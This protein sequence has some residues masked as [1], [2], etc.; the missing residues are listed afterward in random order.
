MKT[1]IPSAMATVIVMAS[2]PAYAQSN[3]QSANKMI[4]QVIVSTPR[5]KAVAKTALPVTVLSGETLF[6]NIGNT[7]G[8]TLSTIPGLSSASFGPSVGQPVIRG[9]QGPRVSVL[10]N[11]MRS[12]DAST[13]SADH[14]VSVEPILADSI[15]VLRG[16]STL[17]YG[18]GAIGG[19]V[20]VIDGRIPTQVPKELGGAAEV[21]H[22]TVN[23]ETTA[24]FKLTGG[25]GNMAFY[26]DAM[27]R[28][29][30]DTE[31]PGLA[32]HEHEEDHDEGHD[33][34][35]EEET[36]DGFISNTQSETSSFTLGGSYVFDKG[37]IGLAVNQLDNEYG[38]P[39]GAHA[40]EEDEMAEE[41]E[42]E[43]VSLDIEQTR[44]DLKGQLEQVSDQI[45]SVR[46]FYTYTDYEHI[47]FEGDEVGTTWTRDSWENRVEVLHSELNGWRGAIGFQLA[48]YELEAVGEESYLPKTQTSNWGLFIVE[49]FTRG[50]WTYELGARIDDSEVEVD[51]ANESES[52][53][54]ISWSTS[55]LWQ[56]NEAWNI[57]LSFSSSE[58]APMAEEL[59]SNFGNMADDFVEHV[60]T[61]AIEVGD[62]DLDNEQANNLDLSFNYSHGVVNASVTVFYN[63]FSDY[64]YL[65]NTGEEQDETPI[66]EYRQEDATFHGV[67]FEVDVGLGSVAGGN[68]SLG[69]FGDWIDGELDDAGDVSRLPPQKLGS[70]LSFDM[71]K[72]SSYISVVDASDQDKPGANEEETEGYTR[73]DAGI[74]YSFIVQSDNE[75]LTFVKLKNISD[76]EIRN[77]S[78]FLR[79]VAP[80]AGRSLEAGVRFIF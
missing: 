57:G 18:G 19:V 26:I 33:E 77:S 30:N 68:L 66:L 15:E 69:F 17:L 39:A 40:H 58:R 34:E 27:Q 56:A 23:D 50:D 14:A 48:E 11:S 63:D 47:E 31:I 3:N 22:G 75:L 46:W 65:A 4:E 61:G 8:E 2:L 6:N 53:T 32:A 20:N 70:R 21:R 64:I 73:W 10:Q 24:V 52:F 67:E 76:E 80:E 9:Q 45:E 55:A 44:Y 25:Q 62:G 37:F 79:E 5:S 60:A 49:D 74:S 71:G 13:S 12:A 42:E 35:H 59:Y 36:T 78:S 43:N 51:G 38:I 29:S 28:E 41:E 16:P 1:F 54:S 7:I 72:L